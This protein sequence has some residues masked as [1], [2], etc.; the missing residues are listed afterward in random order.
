[1]T[2]EKKIEDYLHL[3]LGCECH[4]VAPD[5]IGHMIPERI[6]TYWIDRSRQDGT[7]LIPILRPLSD[8]T[9][10]E[11]SGCWR[12]A[13]GSTQ[14]TNPKLSLQDLTWYSD[15]NVYQWAI[16]FKHLLSKHFDLFGL[17]ESRLAIQKPINPTV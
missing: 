12:L 16:V 14:V 2:P 10:E 6:N 11:A 4:T 8:M 13:G 3:Y 7:V 17:I 1:M 5:G 15:F 9:E